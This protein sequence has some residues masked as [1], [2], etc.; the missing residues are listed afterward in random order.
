VAMEKMSIKKEI[1]AAIRYIYMIINPIE[2]K[3]D[4][5]PSP[6]V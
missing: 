1:I 4:R 6:E 2:K 5:K 3:Y